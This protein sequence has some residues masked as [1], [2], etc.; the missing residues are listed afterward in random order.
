MIFDNVILI[1]LYNRSPSESRTLISL[2]NCD[3]YLKNTKVILWNN[4]PSSISSASISKELTQRGYFFE[5]IETL[6]NESLSYIY[7]K[8][9]NNNS[10]GRYILLDHDSVLND[11]YLKDVSALSFNCVGMPLIYVN[12]VVVNPCINNRIMIQDDNICDLSENDIITTIG[13]GIVI[14]SDVVSQVREKF[15]SVFDE[16][17]YLY[18]VDTTFCF[19]IHNL[20]SA[21]RIKIIYGI[22]HSLSRLESESSNIKKFR[23]KERS[24]DLA[25]QLRFYSSK[26]TLFFKLP[27]L[28]ASV[29]KKK[30]LRKE[31]NI[32]IYYFVLALVKGR[33]YK[34]KN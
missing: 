9:L 7:N 16:R 20:I 23:R 11:S 21:D 28:I 14:G 15:G 5:Y 6:N 10:A 25:L 1:L 31:S 3:F 8:V 29:I 32:E 24:F 18:G 19:R 22:E 2:L 34:V 27:F 26:K 13:S 4:G 12:G 17:F 30:I 33:H